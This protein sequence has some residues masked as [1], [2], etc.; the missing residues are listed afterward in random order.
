MRYEEWVYGTLV[1]YTYCTAPYSGSISTCF[2]HS[3]KDNGMEGTT[4]ATSLSILATGPEVLSD[5]RIT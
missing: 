2:P 1:Q 4:E 3:R 5:L